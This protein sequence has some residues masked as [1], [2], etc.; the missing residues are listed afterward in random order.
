[1]SSHSLS[2]T[3]SAPNADFS[4]TVVLDQQTVY[5]GTVPNLVEINCAIPEDSAQHALTIAMSGKNSTHTQIDTDGNIVADATLEFKNF[6]IAGVDI[7][8]IVYKNA[9]YQ[10]Q[11]NSNGPVIQDQFYG[12]MGCNGVVTL[13]F[14][15]PVYDWIVEH[16]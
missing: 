9:V 6:K 15:T 2:F 16:L 8:Q 10:H 7:D 12:T 13:S 11:Y 14:C 1:M 3:A 4:L 5:Q